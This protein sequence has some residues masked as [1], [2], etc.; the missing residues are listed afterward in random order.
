MQE[1]HYSFMWSNIV[2]HLYPKK[3]KETACCFV[4]QYT[5]SICC[6][7]LIALNQFLS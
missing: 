6:D 5:N 3:K 7:D 2:F 1:V 4:F